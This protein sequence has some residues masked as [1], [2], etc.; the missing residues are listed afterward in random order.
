MHK[1]YAPVSVWEKYQRNVGL[2][3]SSRYNS[4]SYKAQAMHFC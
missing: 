4:R 3:L 1:R 2:S